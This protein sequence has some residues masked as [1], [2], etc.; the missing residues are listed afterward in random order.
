MP[1]M[2]RLSSLVAAG[3]PAVKVMASYHTNVGRH[4]HDF[5]ELVYVTEGY[6]LHSVEGFGSLL[7]EGDVFIIPPGVSHKYSGNRVTRIYNCVFGETALEP[8]LEE[9]KRLPGLDALFGRQ[10]GADRPRLRLSLN[11][12]KG[13]LRRINA[14][15]EECTA[16]D[17]GWTVRLP[18][19][20]V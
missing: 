4:D 10:T 12:R 5:Y 9:L 8:Y 7:M 15:C 3:D 1:N 20:L 11:E 6:C 18:G 13:F 17:P 14:M 16:K 19:E 2:I